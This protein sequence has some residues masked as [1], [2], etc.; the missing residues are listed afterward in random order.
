MC[1]LLLLPHLFKSANSKE[2]KRCAIFWTVSCEVAP[3]WNILGFWRLGNQSYFSKTGFEGNLKGALMQIWMQ[4]YRIN[5]DVCVHIE[6]IPW[7]FRI[8]LFVCLFVYL[9]IY[10]FIYLSFWEGVLRLRVL[11]KTNLIS[12]DIDLCYLL[13]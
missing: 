13:F 1:K 5:K 6:T 3:F 10:L 11:G 4:M 8:Y 7:K 9:F 2:K 12:C